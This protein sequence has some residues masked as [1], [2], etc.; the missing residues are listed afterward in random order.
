M[1]IFQVDIPDG[2]DILG[3]RGTM[4]QDQKKQIMNPEKTGKLA[5][6]CNIRTYMGIHLGYASE[7]SDPSWISI[8]DIHD[9]CGCSSRM[10]TIDIYLRY[11]HP[12]RTW[13]S[14]RD[15]YD[16]YQ[17]PSRIASLISNPKYGY[18]K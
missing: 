8:W 11:G 15:I 10:L 9:E 14:I 16:G 5:L 12:S 2:F 6:F 18:P 17:C 1:S 4:L 3:R 13:I 7:I